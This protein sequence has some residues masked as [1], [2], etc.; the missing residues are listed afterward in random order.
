MEIGLRREGRFA[1]PDPA[2]IV[3]GRWAGVS[4][5]LTRMS[6]SVGGRSDGLFFN[7]ADNLGDD[8]QFLIKPG[9]DD[10]I[11]T[12]SFAGSY[13]PATDEWFGSYSSVV[14]PATSVPEGGG[15]LLLFCAALA[16]I[17]GLRLRFA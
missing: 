17:H 6:T 14:S 13:L 1:D 4:G 15:S 12:F 2:D 3:T 11:H 7:D 8:F 5:Q 16:G 10:M 9:S